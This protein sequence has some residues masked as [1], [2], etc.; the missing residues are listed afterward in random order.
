MKYTSIKHISDLH[1]EFG[2]F[3]P[4]NFTGDILILAG[5]ITTRCNPDHL[6]WIANL[7]F[8]HIILI[9][10]NHEYYHGSMEIVEAETR[11]FFAKYPHVHVLQNESITVEGIT[12]HGTTLWTNFYEGLPD[13]M[14]A[15]AAGM[16]D[17]H[18]IFYDNFSRLFQP[19]NS[20]TLFEQAVD[21]L[22]RNVKPGDMVITHHAPSLMSI[23]PFFKGNPLNP[24]FVSNL[25]PLIKELKPDYWFHGH[26]HS[27]FKYDCHNTRILCNPRGYN[28]HEKIDNF[29]ANST[30]LIPKQETL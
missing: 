15:A 2:G 10:G 28:G 19:Y 18:V 4:K 24:A 17:F 20:I 21:F 16:A 29:C 5:D 6:L 12:F 27:H 22:Q 25:D 8:K 7:P 11:E 9:F 14:L 26:T 1:L 13:A 30:I 23:A 3:N